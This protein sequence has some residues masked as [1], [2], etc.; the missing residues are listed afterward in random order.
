MK[1]NTHYP[2]RPDPSQPL[3]ALTEVAQVT[4]LL[5]LTDA[6]DRGCDCPVN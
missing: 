6:D 1:M 3:S 5:S 4:Q 2:I